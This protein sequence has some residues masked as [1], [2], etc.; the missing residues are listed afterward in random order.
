[1]DFEKP[2]SQ[3]TSILR[4]YKK[5]HAELKKLKEGLN[6]QKFKIQ[7]KLLNPFFKDRSP[8]ALGLRSCYVRSCSVRSSK[9]KI[10]N[11][12]WARLTGPKVILE[13]NFVE[14]N[15]MIIV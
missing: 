1:M 14:R 8:K 7:L 11:S 6:S 15:L 2:R 4:E 3:N 5:V 10:S 9:S 13:L 12:N